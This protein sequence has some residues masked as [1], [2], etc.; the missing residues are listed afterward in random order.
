MFFFWFDPLIWIESK[1][2]NYK[3]WLKKNVRWTKEKKSIFKH[4][5]ENS[6]YTTSV[7]PFLS[8]FIYAHILNLVFFLL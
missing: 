2:V 8:F 5:E 1:V 7:S 3:H 6:V 4:D